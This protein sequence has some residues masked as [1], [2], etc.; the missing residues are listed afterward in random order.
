M[1]NKRLNDEIITPKRF[2]LSMALGSFPNIFFL[3]AV[4]NQIL[5]GEYLLAGILLGSVFI[6]MSITY[7]F[8]N[9][10]I[11]FAV[12]HNKLPE[13]PAGPGPIEELD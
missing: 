8:R 6:L 12:K 2:I 5:E 11:H 10:I 13:I 7:F 9:H 1:M 4:G 3:C